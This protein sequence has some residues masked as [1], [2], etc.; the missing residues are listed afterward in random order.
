MDTNKNLEEGQCEK[1]RQ[2]FV[3]PMKE[4]TV[5]GLLETFRLN[6]NEADP[7]DAIALEG[8]E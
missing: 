1:F 2:Q 8:D 4:I 3:E 6:G 5:Q 7:L